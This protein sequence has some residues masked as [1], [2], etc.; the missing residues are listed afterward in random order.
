[1]RGQASSTANAEFDIGG[2]RFV[3]KQGDITEENVDA[4]V[5]STNSQLD[6]SRGPL[7]F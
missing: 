4:I 5:N 6:L 1:M 7:F 2:L 3:I